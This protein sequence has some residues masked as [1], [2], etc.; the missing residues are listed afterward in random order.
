VIHLS[1]CGLCGVLLRREFLI[2]LMF[3]LPGD[4]GHAGFRL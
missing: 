3:P 2:T 4:I 1:L